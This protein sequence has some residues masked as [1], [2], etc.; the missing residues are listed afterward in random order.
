MVTQRMIKV[1]YIVPIVMI[2]ALLAVFNWFSITPGSILAVFLLLYMFFASILFILLHFGIELF[3]KW[4]SRR[5]TVEQRR[6][7]IGVKKAY[8]ISSVVAFAPVC[9]MAIQSIGQ[10]Q[11]RDILLVSLL[12]GVAAFYIVK[13]A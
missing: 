2:A 8:Y 9:L 3:A 13:R 5:K 7:K 6:W 12:T 1:V 11:L 4:L 10:L